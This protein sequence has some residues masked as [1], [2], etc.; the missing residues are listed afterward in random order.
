MD[1]RILFNV[2][3]VQGLAGILR[4][5]PHA[6]QK[7]KPPDNVIE[8]ESR[9]F[10]LSSNFSPGWQSQPVVW[11]QPPRCQRGRWPE[12]QGPRWLGPRHALGRR[13]AQSAS[14][15]CWHPQQHPRAAGACH[16][17]TPNATA[18][19]RLSCSHS[20]SH[21]WL[22]GQHLILINSWNPRCV[23]WVLLA[24]L[25]PVAVPCQVLPST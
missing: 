2:T 10:G 11:C 1:L 7:G 22:P 13:C 24:A 14:H 18:R 5:M 23:P 21:P 19:S 16:P 17:Q 6:Q 8:V 15:G 4:D 20:P 3:S 12:G 25:D 9:C